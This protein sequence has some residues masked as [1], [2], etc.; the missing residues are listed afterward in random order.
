MVPMTVLSVSDGSEGVQGRVRHGPDPED[1]T[2]ITVRGEDCHPPSA[3]QVRYDGEI[4]V[5]MFFVRRNPDH[6]REQLVL[7]TQL[8][9]PSKMLRYR[10]VGEREEESLIEVFRGEIIPA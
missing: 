2:I 1:T 6:C 5:G 8:H 10:A 4:E 3:G 9:L 7:I